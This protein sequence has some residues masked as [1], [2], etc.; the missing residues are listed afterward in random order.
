MVFYEIYIRWRSVG[1]VFISNMFIH[2]DGEWV[3][4]RIP[5]KV[6]LIPIVQ[7]Q[8]YVSIVVATDAKTVA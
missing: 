8:L 1:R 7:C 3:V 5:R 4:V 2:R 6:F